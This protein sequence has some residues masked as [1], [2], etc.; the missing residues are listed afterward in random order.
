M[1]IYASITRN[2]SQL[3]RITF[4]E[5]TRTKKNRTQGK[6]IP[7]FPIIPNRKYPVSIFPY[8]DS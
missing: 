6:L 1:L 3:C 4:V 8:F 7:T 2:N 5:V